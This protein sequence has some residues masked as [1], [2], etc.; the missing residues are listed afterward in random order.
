MKPEPHLSQPAPFA[1]AVDIGGTKADVGFVDLSGRLL[2]LPGA[3]AAPAID[4]HRVPFDPNGI[5]DPRGLIELLA[6]YIHRASELPGELLGIGLSVCGNIDMQTGE[7]VLVPNLHW[8][9]MPFGRM[10]QD[11]FGLPV[12]SATDVRMAALAEAVWGVAR[13]RK[14]FAWCTIGTGYGGYLFLNGRLYDGMH[15]FAGNF[16]HNTWDEVNGY[17]CGCGRRGCVETFVAGPAIARA[18]QQAVDAGLSPRLASL[19]GGAPVKTVMVFEAEAQGDP[20]AHAILEQAVRLTAINLGGLI[21]IL[22][23]ELIVVGGS[24]ARHHPDY[25][26]RIDLA[27]RKYMETAE[28]Q[29]DLHLALESLPNSAVF[30]AAAEVFMR[31]GM[32]SLPG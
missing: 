25:V 28:A 2:R 26:A 22:D 19:A 21:N 15:G 10:T 31:A 23:L 32:L 7:A 13:G 17:L 27:M 30:G 4:Q 16:G 18:G 1:L 3:Q 14:H 5:A 6:P 20:A 24:V 8:R 9:N 29:R 11:R 12:W